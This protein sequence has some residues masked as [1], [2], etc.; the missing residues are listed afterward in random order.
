[1]VTGATSGIGF[2]TAMALARAGADVIL[3]GR[4]E[5]DAPE[6]LAAIR[7]LASGSLVR[8]EKLDL[9]NLASVADFAEPHGGH[10]SPSRHSDQQRGRDGAA[11]ASQ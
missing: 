9:A 8:F 4:N 10:E 7:P 2:E 1:M 5:T 11:L 6:A 3:A